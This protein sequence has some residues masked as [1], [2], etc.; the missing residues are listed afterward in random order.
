MGWEEENGIVARESAWSEMGQQEA[1]HNVLTS[2]LRL[3]KE[4]SEGK[5]CSERA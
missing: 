2:R 5:V 4:A 1:A 3:I